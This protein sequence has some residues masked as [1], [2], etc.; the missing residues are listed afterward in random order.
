M[1]YTKYKQYPPV[2]LDN[3]EWPSKV[4]DKA[5]LWCSVDLPDGNQTLPIPMSIN[6]KI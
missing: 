2:K 3:R 1:D 4:L 5:P 6:E